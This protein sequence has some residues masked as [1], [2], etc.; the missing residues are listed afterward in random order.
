MAGAW[1]VAGE[2]AA[3]GI[4]PKRRADAPEIGRIGA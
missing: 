2:P 3:V 1:P 4:V